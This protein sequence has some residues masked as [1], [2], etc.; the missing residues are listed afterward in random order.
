MFKIK[1]PLFLLMQL[2]F[3]SFSCTAGTTGTDVTR[4]P[5]YVGALGGF[6][7][8]T[9]KGLVPTQEN[10]NMALILST[11]IEVNEGGTVWGVF[12]GYEFSPNFSI[13][14][15][16]THYPEA[17]VFFDSMSLFSFNNN[18]QLVFNTQTETVSL[19]GKIMLLIP[20]TSIRIY[21]SAGIADIH[22]D[23]ILINQWLVTPTF[24]A[25]LNYRIMDHLMVELGGN[26]TAGFGESQLEP[27][28]SYIPFLYSVSLRLAYLF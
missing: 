10:Q 5:F 21:S 28:S 11:P 18:G 3:I 22:R 13:E 12:T 17:K 27:T 19:M 26:Y 7:S 25:G 4:H 6:G 16:Y 2:C 1:F 14:A 9:W 8:T 20:N 24:G 15:N 23:D